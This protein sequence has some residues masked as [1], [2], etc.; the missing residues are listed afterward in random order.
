[1][2]KSNDVVREAFQAAFA[3]VSDAGG[4]TDVKCTR[5]AELASLCAHSAEELPRVL[6]GIT[7][8]IVD[9][10]VQRSVE[11]GSAVVIE[12]D[13]DGKPRTLRS[14]EHM[15]ADEV[16]GHVARLRT[17]GKHRHANALERYAANRAA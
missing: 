8:E 12:F 7:A 1:M 15:T 5:L 17:E 6:K 14:T 2:T 4:S 9:A 10:H 16:A 11:T 13:A 3:I